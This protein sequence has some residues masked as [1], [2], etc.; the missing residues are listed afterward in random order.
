MTDTLL[1]K[2][3]GISKHF[4]GVQAL[5]TVSL[6]VAPGEIHGLLGENGAGKSTLLKT[7]S[8]AYHQDA[9]TIEQWSGGQSRTAMRVAVLLRAAVPTTPSRWCI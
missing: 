9:G 7:L 8:G 1:L 5:D 6:E 2:M 4:P 3:T